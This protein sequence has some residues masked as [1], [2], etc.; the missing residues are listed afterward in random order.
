MPLIFAEP[1]SSTAPK[2]PSIM[3]KPYNMPMHSSLS[4]LCPAQGY[5]APNFRYVFRVNIGWIPWQFSEYI[6]YRKDIVER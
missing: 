3:T 2:I 4:I 1:V 6:D 5:P